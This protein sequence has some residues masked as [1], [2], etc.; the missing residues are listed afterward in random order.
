MGSR[1]IFY[2]CP[3]TKK[4]EIDG[5]QYELLWHPTWILDKAGKHGVHA[6][7]GTPWYETDSN[8]FSPKPLSTTESSP[9]PMA[10]SGEPLPLVKCKKLVPIVDKDDFADETFVYRYPKNHENPTPPTEEPYATDEEAVK[11]ATDWLVKHF[12]RLPPETALVTTRVQRSSSGQDKPAYDWDRGHTI[13]LCQTF[14]GTP[15]SNDT[16]LYITGKTRFSGSIGLASFEPIPGSAK[17]TISKEEA[18]KAVRRMAEARGATAKHLEDLDKRLK[19]VL[20]YEWSPTY[21]EGFDLDTPVLNPNWH[22]IPGEP[23]MVDAHTGKLW[24]ND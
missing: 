13:V 17:P 11:A 4:Q 14:R 24:V 8:T 12:G 1:L 21:N 9:A 5:V 10:K 2:R 16:I 20:E 6:Q 23:L 3:G 22:M 7:D 19:P 15:T 18:V